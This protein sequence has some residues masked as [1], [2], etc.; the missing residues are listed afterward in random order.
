MVKRVERK[1]V[2]AVVTIR[3]QR[4]AGVPRTAERKGPGKT[5]A[6]NLPNLRGKSNTSGSSANSE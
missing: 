5:V 6:G 4:V 1:A 2:S 3:P